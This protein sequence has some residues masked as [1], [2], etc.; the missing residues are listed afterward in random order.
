MTRCELDVVKAFLC[1]GLSH[2][3][4]QKNILRED[5]P[6]RGGGFLAMNILHRFG[7]RDQ[8]K[9]ILRGRG[10][11]ENLFS[12]K[13]HIKAYLEAIESANKNVAPILTPKPIYESKEYD[14]SGY[15]KIGYVANGFDRFEFDY[16]GYGRDG[17][18]TEPNPYTEEICPT[19]HGTGKRR[20]I[21]EK[22]FSVVEKCKF[23]NGS[24]KIRKVD[25]LDD[26]LKMAEQKAEEAR[27][28]E[29]LEH[30]RVA[31]EIKRQQKFE[32]LE[33]QRVAKIISDIGKYE[34]IAAN[35]HAQDLKDI[36]WDTLVSTYPEAKEVNRY[37]VDAF[38][39]N[40]GIVLVEGSALDTR[41][42]E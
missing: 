23:C 14:S 8:H 24:G 34:N 27:R 21:Q 13:R 5:A 1:N 17:Y 39:T 32:R 35:Q 26:L 22:F 38:L 28:P 41:Q 15:N 19:C 9:N 20:Y 11:D 6:V 29:L 31:E 37:D 10:F 2:R 12:E 18:N 16:D 33:R 36:A 40:L 7:I 4:I 3:E 25:R 42:N 30:Q